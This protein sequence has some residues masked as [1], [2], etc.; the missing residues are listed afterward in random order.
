MEKSLNTKN[1]LIAEENVL[2]WNTVQEGFKRH[3][4][5]KFT[6]AGL[7]MFLLL[8]NTTIM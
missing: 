8:R 2:N 6:Q 1:N 3:L 4:V 5:P 7:K